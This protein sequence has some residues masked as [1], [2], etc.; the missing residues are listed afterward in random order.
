ME[1]KNPDLNEDK[2]TDNKNININNNISEDKD[3]NDEIK[4]KLGNRKSKS[5]LIT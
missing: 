3:K 4:K 1:E 5:N 2:D